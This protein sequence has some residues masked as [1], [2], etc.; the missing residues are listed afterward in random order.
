MIQRN[1]GRS[2]VLLLLFTLA[3]AAPPAGRGDRGRDRGR[4][5]PPPPVP[6]PAYDSTYKPLPR[7]DTL[8]V[9]ANVLDGAGNRYSGAVLVRDG[10]IAAVGPSASAQSAAVTIDA[11]GRWLTPGIIDIHSHNGTY[12]APLTANL[13]CRPHGAIVRARRS[14]TSEPSRE[15][16]S[17][18]N[19]VPNIMAITGLISWRAR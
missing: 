4:D 1:W 9:N 11:N 2:A 13:N 18:M 12:V 14:R 5:R 19:K 10:K 6:T 7:V 17:G 8:I 3:A 15:R 16:T